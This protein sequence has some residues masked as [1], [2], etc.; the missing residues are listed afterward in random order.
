MI[1]NC[2]EFGMFKVFKT[3]DFAY[4]KSFL[5]YTYDPIL[6]TFSIMSFENFEMILK[7]LFEK[8]FSKLPIFYVH[9]LFLKIEFFKNFPK[10]DIKLFFIGG[11]NE[12]SHMLYIM[13]F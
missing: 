3:F 5:I 1:Y 2:H 7:I 9:H 8:Y 13:Y 12:F 11:E 10:R 4:L 6:K